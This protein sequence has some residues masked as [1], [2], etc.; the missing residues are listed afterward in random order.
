MIVWLKK[1][2]KVYPKKI[3]INNKLIK[4]KKLKVGDPFYLEKY[5]KF[6]TLGINHNIYNIKPKYKGEKYSNWYFND[7]EK[8]IS[9]DSERLVPIALGIILEKNENVIKKTTKNYLIKNN[10]KLKF[11]DK[12]EYLKAKK[13]CK[14]SMSR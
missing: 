4:S 14:S 5:K 7:I 13:I 10:I 3:F 12:T 9:F 1:P 8:L 2:M 6:I 11:F